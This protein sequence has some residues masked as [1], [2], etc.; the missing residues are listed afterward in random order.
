MRSKI[1]Y[2]NLSTT[3]QSGSRD[4]ITYGS[5]G[6]PATT[7]LAIDDDWRIGC[8]TPDHHFD[9]LAEVREVRR[10]LCRDGYPCI[11]QFEM[12]SNMFAFRHDVLQDQHIITVDLFP[13][14]DDGSVGCLSVQK[15]PEMIDFASA[16]SGTE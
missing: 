4:P 3:V 1:T 11:T 16:G 8:V 9:E 15:Q 10:T 2:T 14:W 13:D 12:F 5:Q 7:E 6:A